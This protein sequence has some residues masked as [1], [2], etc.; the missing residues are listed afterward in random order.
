VSGKE[1]QSFHILFS[2]VSFLFSITPQEI[3]ETKEESH[4]GAPSLA[5]KYL[6]AESQAS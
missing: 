2:C 5:T 4:P 6:L 3:P 1:M